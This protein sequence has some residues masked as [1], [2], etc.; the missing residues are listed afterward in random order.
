MARLEYYIGHCLATPP[1]LKVRKEMLM[2]WHMAPKDLYKG[3][4][5][6]L[7]QVYNSRADLPNDKIDGVSIKHL[8]GNGWDRLGY[9]VVFHRNGEKEI[10]TPFDDNNTVESDEMTWGCMGY[11]TGSRH[12]ALEG[13]FKALRNDDFFKH[14]TDEQYLA[15]QMW[16]KTELYKHPQVLVGGHNDFTEE[17]ECPGF[18]MYELMTEF[19]MGKY[20][21]KR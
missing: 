6:Y 5:K 18:R 12:F 10:V 20:A 8:H 16:L 9:S 17:K 11:N 4:V 1:G 7:R 14:F 21:Y 15:V 2:S 13:G 3:K 19:G